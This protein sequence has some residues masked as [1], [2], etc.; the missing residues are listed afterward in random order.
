MR[1]LISHPTLSLCPQHGAVSSS[2]LL[3]P[4]IILMCLS[5]PPQPLT[6]TNIWAFFRI[7]SQQVNGSYL[8]QLAC[9]WPNKSHQV[10]SSAYWITNRP[11]TI[12]CS[13]HLIQ[14]HQ[15]VISHQDKRCFNLQWSHSNRDITKR[16][17]VWCSRI[18][19]KKLW[20]AL[21]HQDN[22]G[23]D[24]NICHSF[25]INSHL[26]LTITKFVR[27]LSNNSQLL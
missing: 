20:Q 4:S 8:Q 1:T 16:V 5:H 25:S 19:N 6:H 12:C 10:L 21:I 13:Q 11:Q 23:S 7:H 2:S 24:S 22:W 15:S 18:R 26:W 9:L 14:S 3:L 17:T 27:N